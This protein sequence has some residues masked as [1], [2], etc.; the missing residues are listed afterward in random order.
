MSEAQQLTVLNIVITGA[1]V[2][3]LDSFFVNK[4]TWLTKYD[5]SK[6]N[7]LA[8]YYL[9]DEIFYINLFKILRLNQKLIP[10]LT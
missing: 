4:Y 2:S 3:N 9:L 10:F 5:R 1:E 7:M 6:K 8:E